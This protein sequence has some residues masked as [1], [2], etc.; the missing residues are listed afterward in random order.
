MVFGTGKNGKSTTLNALLGERLLP[1]GTTT[2]TGNSTEMVPVKNAAGE[3]IVR[4]HDRDQPHD[5]WRQES[6]LPVNPTVDRM[7]EEWVTNERIDRI[8]IQHKHDIF[9]RNV[10]LL[11]VPGCALISFTGSAG[12]RLTD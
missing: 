11:D 6:L 5:E 1:S 4:I 9:R 10:K 3:E 8:S 7:S 2:C 12:R